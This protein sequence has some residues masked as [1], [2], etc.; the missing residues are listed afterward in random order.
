MAVFKTTATL[1]R[2]SHSWNMWFK[3]FHSLSLRNMSLL[4]ITVSH[5][6]YFDE[7]GAVGHNIPVCQHRSLWVPLKAHTHF[8]Y[9]Y[10]EGKYCS[11]CAVFFRYWCNLGAIKS[12]CVCVCHLLF[13]WW[14]RWLP[15]RQFGEAGG[16]RSEVKQCYI[17]QQ[18][19][20]QCDW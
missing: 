19:H 17:T 15:C 9:V 1:E 5:L 2:C 20:L 11:R 18:H 3:P 7:G 14:N 6:C 4:N 10:L 12:E 8:I 13:H 16:M